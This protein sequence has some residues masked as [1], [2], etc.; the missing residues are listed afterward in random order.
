MT[1]WTRSLDRVGL[2]VLTLA[3][4]GPT[5]AEDASP[6]GA[7]SDLDVARPEDKVDVPV[8]PP[9]RG[10]IVLFDGTG[11]SLEQWVQTDGRSPA[12]W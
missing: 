8:A 1:T 6:Y 9:P 4:A 11:E 2:L 3:L 10:A 5:R 7:I 12:P